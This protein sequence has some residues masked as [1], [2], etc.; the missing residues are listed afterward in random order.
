M[1]GEL[2][3][4]RP[5]IATAEGSDLIQMQRDPKYQVKQDI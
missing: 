1:S 4:L 2:E 5:A 3:S